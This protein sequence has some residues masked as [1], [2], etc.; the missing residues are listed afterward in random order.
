MTIPVSV[1]TTG[2]IMSS[3]SAEQ[4]VNIVPGCNQVFMSP[5]LTTFDFTNDTIYDLYINFNVYC[6]SISYDYHIP[7]SGKLLKA[8]AITSSL[9]RSI[10]SGAINIYALLPSG[11][12]QPVNF[13]ANQLTIVGYPAGKYGPTQ[14]VQMNR[15]SNVGN[16]V[17]AQTQTFRAEYV[18]TGG[19][20]IAFTGANA[21]AGQSIYFKSIDLTGDSPASIA[22]GN[23]S[24]DHLD[25]LYTNSGVLNWRITT[26]QSGEGR[27]DFVR[28]FDPPVKSLTS[29]GNPATNI[30]NVTIGNCNG[31]LEQRVN[32][33]ALLAV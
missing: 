15:L 10:Y 29:D 30:L 17:I 7:P 1:N 24:M 27:F 32:L 19:I 21:P 33:T 9:G 16:T 28:N 5:G 12:Y 13:P 11:G 20:N 8:K 31:G 4:K 23:I 18:A 22:S 14:L 25:P 2:G 3:P 26:L 6:G